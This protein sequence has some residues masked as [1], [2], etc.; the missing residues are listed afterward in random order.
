MNNVKTGA[1][2]EITMK[3]KEE[4]RAL[5]AAVY[6]KYRLPFLET[7]NGALSKNLLLRNEDVQVLHGFTDKNEAEAYLISDLFNSDVVVE[8]KPYFEES[9]C[10]RIYTVIG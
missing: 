6:N 1:Y 4:N 9:P 8:L 5:A 10:I 3:I 7:I 2:L